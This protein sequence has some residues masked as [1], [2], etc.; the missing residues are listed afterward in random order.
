MGRIPITRGE[1][2]VLPAGRDSIGAASKSRG[3]L[4]SVRSFQS[5]VGCPLMGRFRP[6]KMMPVVCRIMAATDPRY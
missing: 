2:A 5:L 4:H 6:L 1:L 3:Y